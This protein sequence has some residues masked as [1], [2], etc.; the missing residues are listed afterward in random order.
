MKQ[1]SF[2]PSD[3]NA[4]AKEIFIG[5]V[6]R[7]F[8]KEGVDR[9]V[10]ELLMLI[11]SE[12]GECLEAHRKGRH[13]DTEK[14]QREMRDVNPDHMDAPFKAIFERNIKDTVEDELADALIRILDMAAGLGID[15]G[16]HVWA[17]LEYNATRE[18]LHGKKY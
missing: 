18:A 15:I 16:W 5:N 17:K 11:T 12:L 1:A 13:A 6:M 8:W 7:G 10:G 2:L 9:N 4:L 14:F 3:M